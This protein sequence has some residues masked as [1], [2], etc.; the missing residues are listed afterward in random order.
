MG[1][2][3]QRRGGRGGGACSLEADNSAIEQLGRCAVYSR[4]PSLARLAPRG[5]AAS[6]TSPRGSAPSRPRDGLDFG[7]GGG[8]LKKNC[9]GLAGQCTCGRT[10]ASGG[11]VTQGGLSP[12]HPKL[13]C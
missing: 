6:R 7:K 8:V 2:G 10:R 12:P 13:A 5:A 9:H 11:M 3:G 4:S 1:G